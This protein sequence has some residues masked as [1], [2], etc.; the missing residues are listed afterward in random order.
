MASSG[1]VADDELTQDE[2]V[3]IAQRHHADIGWALCAQWRLPT[4]IT[5]LTAT[6]HAPK[7]LTLDEKALIDVVLRADR[8]VGTVLAHGKN[9]VAAIAAMPD[10][11]TTQ[12]EFIVAALARYGAWHKVLRA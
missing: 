2:L 4:S 6:H 7:A 1:R 9:D 11:G 12:P 8:L 3:A 10:R 5:S